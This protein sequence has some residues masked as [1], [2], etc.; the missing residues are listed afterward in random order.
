MCSPIRSCRDI[1]PERALHHPAWWLALAVLVIN[2][3]LLKGWGPGW[4]T[5]KLSDFAGLFVAPAL[6]AALLRIRHNRGL[7]L[8]HVGVGAGFAAINLVAPI[9]RGIE[10]LTSAVGFAWRIWTDPGDLVALCVLPVA[11]Q[12]F[13]PAMRRPA[14]RNRG[15][16]RRVLE[17]A[18]LLAGALGSMATSK[19]PPEAVV[20]TPG[21]VIAQGWTNDPVYVVDTASGDRLHKLT[22][23]EV[24]RSGARLVVGDVL[25]T[26]RDSSVFG[27]RLSD[28]AEVLDYTS[29]DASFHPLAVTDG[30][31]LILMSR[32]AGGHSMERMVSLGLDGQVEWSSALPSEMSWRGVTEGPILSSGLLIVTAGDELVALDPTGGERRWTYRAGIPLKWVVGAG[33]MACAVDKDGGLHVIDAASG[34][35]SWRGQSINTDDTRWADDK[36]IGGTADGTLAFLRGDRLV[37][38]DASTQAIRWQGPRHIQGITFGELYAVAWLGEAEE[39]H[40]YQLID[41]RTGRLA[42]VR[43]LDADPSIAPAIAEADGML[44]FHP[45]YDEMV[46]YEL[47]SGERRWA[48]DLDDGSPVVVASSDGRVLIA[49]T[50]RSKLVR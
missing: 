18:G 40:R 9:A 16:V 3:H 11:W 6:L 8:A 49:G 25:Y 37:A 47:S 5:G 4:L 28:G 15:Q 19:A 13:A 34:R 2:D 12:L 32:P 31:R 39:G 44:L 24:S 43:A 1:Q 35:I 30:R 22:T 27:H 21:R 26:V 36:P 29:D 41:L 20:V 17:R 23:P 50:K 42:W 10:A 46:A 45:S 7:L 48:F 33:R 38:I 14:G